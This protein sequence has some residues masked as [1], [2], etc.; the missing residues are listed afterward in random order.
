METGRDGKRTALLEALRGVDSPLSSNRLRAG[1]ARRGLDASDRSV[2]LYLAELCADGLAAGHGRRGY[3]LTEAGLAELQAATALDRVGLLSSKIDALT[4]RTD[5]DPVARRG[6]VVVN[7]SVVP[8]EA[9]RAGAGHMVELFSRGLAMGEL[10]CL[11]AP[12]ER[13]EEIAVPERAVGVCTVCS[14]TVN[15]VLLQR[16]I[17]I[18]SRFGGV[19]EVVGGRPARFAA[20]IHYGG[21][22]VDPLEIFLRGGLTDHLG[23]L[24]TGRGLIGAGFRGIPAHSRPEVAL[25]AGQLRGAGLGAVLEIGQPGL[26]LFEVSVEAGYAG[27]VVA[28]GLNPLSVLAENG[29][30]VSCRALAGL[31]DYQRLFHYAELPD[32]LSDLARHP[33]EISMNPG[34]REFVPAGT[35]PPPSCECER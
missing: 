14:I 2:R 26:P 35:D 6:S 25:A 31:L 30:R 3:L 1:L 29:H 22:T 12:G 28:G 5:F 15:G 24:R 13:V 4:Y 18:R 32:R 19:L 8:L 23:V 17:P 20:L 11:L 33:R 10:L 21:T 7:A 27:M 16:G 34:I 9:L